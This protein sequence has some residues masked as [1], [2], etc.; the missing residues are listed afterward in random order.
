MRKLRFK[1]QSASLMASSSSYLLTDDE[2][3]IEGLTAGVLDMIATDL[4]ITVSGVT[5]HLAAWQ[6][7]DHWADDWA[8]TLGVPAEDAQ[9]AVE[10]LLSATAERE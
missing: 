5:Q 9:Q 8:Q 1:L 4:F 10:E 2:D 3:I 6:A 7:P